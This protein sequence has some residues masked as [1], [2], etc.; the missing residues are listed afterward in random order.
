MFKCK[1]KKSFGTKCTKNVNE[2]VVEQRA[3]AERPEAEQPRSSCNKMFFPVPCAFL[4]SSRA[5]TRC[6]TRT[7]TLTWHLSFIIQVLTK[8][9]WT[10]I[11]HKYLRYMWVIIKH[12]SSASLMTP[13]LDPHLNRFGTNLRNYESTPGPENS[14]GWRDSPERWRLCRS[15]GPWGAGRWGRAASRPPSCP[16]GPADSAGEATGSDLRCCCYSRSAADTQFG[17]RPTRTDD[18]P[19]LQVQ[20]GILSRTASTPAMFGGNWWTS[21]P[22][23]K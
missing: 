1:R 15:R 16:A 11:I 22:V 13:I 14:P 18:A 12:I 8:Q 4:T 10:K 17:V 7:G 2:C 6:I 9:R 23:V 20:D 3:A 21:E 5:C 19:F